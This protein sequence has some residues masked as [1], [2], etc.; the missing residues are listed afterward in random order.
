MTRWTQRTA[1]VLAAA[2]L[3]WGQAMEPSAQ[4][5]LLNI[6]RGLGA[7]VKAE[8]DRPVR[9]I[10]VP[11]PADPDLVRVQQR[12]NA[13][14]FDVG[15][16]DGLMGEKTRKAVVDYQRSIGRPPTG[17]LDAADRAALFGEQ[18]P[19]TQTQEAT[20][21]SPGST[22]S[23]LYDVDL[24]ENDFRSGMS[25]PALKQIGIDGCMAACSADGQCQA[26]TYNL[27]VGICFLKTA[28]ANPTPFSGA[29]SGI[30]GGPKMVAAAP[31]A[32]SR[33]LT[34]SEV[35]QLQAG[36]NARG[37]DAGPPDGVA[38]A[39]T[40][41]AIARFAAENPSVGAPT[42]TFGM[43]QAVL[44]Q[45]GAVAAPLPVMD[46]AAY[47]GF[48]EVDH[49]LALIAIS[50]D[51]TILDDRNL[52][53]RWFQREYPQS[54]QPER[55]A[56]DYANSVQQDAILENLRQRILGEAKAKAA[57]PGLLPLR[58]RSWTPIQF[59]DFH[60]GK[61]ILA[62]VAGGRVP[63]MLAY[64]SNAV[65]REF[66]GVALDA[67]EIPF[68]PIMDPAEASAFLDRARGANGY[69]A[70]ELVTWY[71]ITEIG[72][73][74][75]LV[76][77][78]A[79]RPHQ[80][81]ITVTLDKVSVATMRIGQDRKGGGEEL[82]VLR[83]PEAPA[84]VPGAGG[85]GVQVAQQMGLP[86]IDGHVLVPADP[87]LTYEITAAF[88]TENFDYKM[89]RY[90][91]LATLR[92][93][94]ERARDKVD[95]RNV[96]NLLSPGQHLRVYGIEQGTFL[97]FQNEFERRRAARV[98]NDEVIPELLLEAPALP[99]PVVSVFR[100]QVGEYDF[101]TS[102]FPLD[103]GQQRPLLALP[104]NLQSAS[105]YRDLPAA[106]PM[107]EAAAEQFI[108]GAQSSGRPWVW[109]ATFGELSL[110]A[111]E[112][113]EERPVNRVVFTPN[114][115]GIFAD[116]FLTTKLVDIDP[117]VS[118]F[119]PSS[120][121]V[122]PRVA[123]AA[124]NTLASIV[125]ATELELLAN[126]YATLAPR[127]A[128]EPMIG[129][130]EAVRQANEFELAAARATAEATL[131]TTPP[132]ESI[133]LTGSIDVG[134]YD[135]AAGTFPMD[136]L[137]LARPPSDSGYAANIYFTIAD[138]RPLQAIAVPEDLARQVV[139]SGRRRLSLLLRVDIL[140]VSVEGEGT[141]TYTYAVDLA[142]AV[143]WAR[144]AG[145]DAPPL[146]LARL[147]VAPGSP[148]TAADLPPVTLL[149]QEGIDYVRFKYAP[150]SF[151]EADFI[152]MMGARWA[153]E[154]ANLTTDGVKFFP[155]NT[156]LLA[157]GIRERW[158][159]GFIAWAKGRAETITNPLTLRVGGG[160]FDC[161][162]GI[163]G[164]FWKSPLRDAM[165][166]AYP[167][168]AS[169]PDLVRLGMGFTAPHETGP[170]A[171]EV[172][173]YLL[174]DP[175]CNIYISTDT[176]AQFGW[177]KDT[178]RSGAVILLD[179]IALPGTAVARPE[180]IELSVD[181]ESVDVVDIAGSS[182]ALAIKV[183]FAGA[184]VADAYQTAAITPADLEALRTA[185]ATP[186]DLP[187]NWDIVGLKPGLTLAQ[188]EEMVREH[189]DVAAVFTRKPGV[190]TQ[191]HFL[192]ERVFVSA[193]L[194]EAIGLVYLPGPDGDIVYIISREVA[195]PAGTMSGTLLGSLRDKYGPERTA[196][197]E[198]N[199]FNA[200]WV[201]RETPQTSANG[202]NCGAGAVSAMEHWVLL[203]G[204][205]DGIDPAVTDYLQVRGYPWLPGPRDLSQETLDYAALD[206]G[207]TIE[208]VKYL[209]GNSDVLNVQI[210]DFEGYV[211]AAKLP[212][213]QAPRTLEALDFAL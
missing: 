94:P 120:V 121:V 141:P 118:V 189:M 173:G 64:R 100:L 150:D 163:V 138:P 63:R 186:S 202:P 115:A 11:N 153:L 77:A 161:V 131:A 213:A 149:D 58:V 107:G 34:P 86:V 136:G 197:D 143:V 3:L 45:P 185:V 132:P 53:V 166:A 9:V 78:S 8:Q 84:Q 23:L 183:R 181:I 170:V 106:L 32:A 1:I 36:L 20:Q 199:R 46:A 56:F 169:S 152:R 5:D 82:Y 37:Y 101:A 61:G 30:R 75:N 39:R 188:S 26:F 88:G 50:Q 85:N 154:Q 134:T 182:P 76:G 96:A 140:D 177:S 160:G 90:Y 40:R 151:A 157:P 117:A 91:S 156:D 98:L 31:D 41:A 97:G 49:I 201:S 83:S 127:G 35:A 105:V 159:P 178:S 172:G 135:L 69:G 102:A 60:P 103:Y 200:L 137:D 116:P 65:G 57:E 66:T 95:D 191:P 79:A 168:I 93:D 13:L 6:L 12:L 119:D 164:E 111:T 2:L 196:N 165:V 51:P 108:L 174:E 198:P 144:L 89:W 123:T 62:Y 72:N 44:Q 42:M 29:A 59:R 48:E 195:Q 14:G 193:D 22:F 205:V 139:E 167:D 207:V 158:L 19:I 52:M 148:I 109:V 24:P 147:N 180:R 70:T 179:T 38:G 128:T 17:Q 175:G 211:R 113:I 92:I 68:I 210:I 15:P 7:A 4:S 25:E 110:A 204:D 145:D 99:V 125:P 176:M 55:Q 129:S 130:S 194:R 190:R 209:S 43:M 81:P 171:F 71:T 133:W 54:N 28:G 155:P 47:L 74:R 33:P 124:E 187:E 122:P 203:E 80:I 10:Q 67:P 206:C 87:Q 146:V 114:R 208:A 16:A 112:T 73:D 18:S 27:A 184:N 104:A 212:Q 126:A 142:E 21:S 162:T 192:N